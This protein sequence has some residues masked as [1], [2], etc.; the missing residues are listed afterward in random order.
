MVGDL[1]VLFV[2]D[3]AHAAP[4]AA[5]PGFQQQRIANCR[6]YRA[7]VVD[8]VQEIASGYDRHT[9]LRCDSTSI[10]FIAHCFDRIR[11]RPDESDAGL[12]AIARETRAL[13]KKAIARM[14]CI[15][16]ACQTCVK[17][18]V[19]AQVTATGSVGADAQRAI[20]QPC[21]H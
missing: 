14:K 19:A 8:I 1:D 4:T 11:R 9:G 12:L 10:A 17:Q 7:G 2:L 15:A 21:S 6:A 18:N 5:G 13:R 20:R 16:A 3:D